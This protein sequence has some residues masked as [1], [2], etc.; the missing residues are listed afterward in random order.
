MLRNYLKIAWRS[1]LKQRVYTLINVLGLSI[2]ITCCVLVMQFVRSEWSFDS[3]HAKADRIH[4]AW[5]EE[6]YK[7][8]I[9]RNTFTPIPLA[10]VVQGAVPDIEAACRIAPSGATLTINNQ[11]FNDNITLV[12]S[13]FFQVFDFVLLEGN[14][15]QP[16]ANANTL[17]LSEDAVLKYFGKS[18]AIGKQIEIELRDGKELFTV[19][20]LVKNPPLESSI[21]FEVLLPFSNAPKL[22][23]PNAINNGWSNVVLET[24][25]LIKDGAEL[26]AVNARIASVLNPLVAKNYKPGEYNVKLQPIG[27]IH[28]NSTLPSDIPKPSDPRYAYILSIVGILVL[29]IACINFVTLAIARSNSRALEVGVRKV[30]GAERR[31][32]IMQFWGEAFLLTIA[33]IALSFVFIFLLQPAFNELANRALQLKADAFTF[34]FFLLLVFV[35]ALLS[36]LY[37]AFVLSG[38]KPI[39]VLK[40]K[41][42]SSGQVGFLRKALVT[43]QFVASI[44][45]IIATLS[46][47]SQL[48]YMMSKNLGYNKD[49]LV[50]L[51]TNLPRRQGM[52][53][54]QLMHTEI[55]SN[56]EVL[57]A[58]TSLY[59]MAE[60]GWMNLGYTD[61]KSVFRRFKFNAVDADF[62]PVM[63]LE[64]VAGRNFSATNP[65]DS[66]Y[67]LVNEALVKEYG[68][69]KPIGQRLPGDYEY[70]VLGVVKDFN[71][72]S[73][74]APVV[75]AVMAMRADSMFSWSSDITFNASPRPRISVRFKGG[76]VKKHI[77]YLEASW[78][79]V[80]GEDFEYG[81]LDASLAASYEQETRL[82]S[83]VRYAS[84]LSVIIACLGL[85]GLSALVVARRTREIGIRKV[86]GSSAGN[87]VVLLSKD[88]AVLI[89]LASLIAFPIAWWAV[90]NWLNDFAYRINVPIDLFF[91]SAF[92]AL[93]VALAT[94]GFQSLKAALMNPVKSLR[95]D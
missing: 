3:M 64:M 45:L 35:I 95:T 92:I 51:Q 71:L 14:N 43:G 29:V 33:A 11:S 22:W 88:F 1:L 18:G 12:D 94:V 83:I 84:I 48:D 8:E 10:P 82:S 16:F 89:L 41:L 44:L 70:T 26:P 5:L 67:I 74:H 66:N 81:F 42:T 23:S 49:H 62:V 73:L 15:A 21:E 52:P 57:G 53:L 24:Y 30:L 61:D 37:P 32:L 39:E 54:A 7:G 93:I 91:F 75:P 6:H 9:F 17:L 56:P 20:G 31:Q 36:G 4:R 28:F 69:K 46:V 25:F 79:K 55:K 60:G 27:D 77:S 13:N 63:Q 68:W 76:D 80:S 90:K 65:A 78:K 2:G 72:E 38:F 86:L 19:G 40:G 47:G 87:I 34:L 85:F 58:T 59:S 50:V